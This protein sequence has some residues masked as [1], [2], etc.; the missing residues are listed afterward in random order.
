VRLT[1][2]STG[3]APAAVRAVG[4]AF[5]ATL[6]AGLLV[7]HSPPAGAEPVA[8]SDRGTGVDQTGVDKTGSGQ[9]G[10]G[11]LAAADQIAAADAAEDLV[12]DIQ[13]SVHSG[14]FQGEVAVSLSTTVSGAQIRYTTNGQLPTAQ[15]TLYSGACAALH[16]LHPAAGPGVCRRDGG[17]GARYRDVLRPTVTARN[18]DYN[19]RLAAGAST[20]F[21]FIA[22]WNGT[23]TS[24]AVTCTA[25]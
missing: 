24:S 10:S 23:S 7:S 11:P 13:F 15:A 3:A 2:P 22:T 9:S 25:Y 12:G 21:G 5:A 1:V 14:T 19:G 17:R 18:V 20:S 16:P 8:G 6:V 4:V